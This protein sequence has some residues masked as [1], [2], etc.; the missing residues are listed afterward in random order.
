[1]TDKIDFMIPE[2]ICHKH[3]QPSNQY[4]NTHNAGSRAAILT[5][6]VT[7]CTNNSQFIITAT[8]LKG[9]VL[10]SAFSRRTRGSDE[11][12]H[13]GL[14]HESQNRRDATSIVKE[15]VPQSGRV[16]RGNFHAVLS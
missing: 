13:Q 2:E 4:E 9:N 10:P 3:I 7:Q 11:C 14:M 16:E 15:N 12:V 6:P 8:A 1:M 5:L